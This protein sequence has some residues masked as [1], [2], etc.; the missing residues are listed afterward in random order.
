MYELIPKWINCSTYEVIEARELKDV[1]FVKWMESRGRVV[2]E[3]RK[4]IRYY[5]EYGHLIEAKTVDDDG[6]E[7]GNKFIKP[8]R[9]YK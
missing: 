7:N 5:M 2:Y 8:Q 9:R 3:D 4:G 6:M 1:R